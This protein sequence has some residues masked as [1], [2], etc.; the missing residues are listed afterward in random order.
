MRSGSPMK[1]VSMGL[2]R[3]RNRDSLFSLAG[4]SS[5]CITWS[6]SSSMLNCRLLTVIFPLSILLISS[7]SLI[8]E[9]RYSLDIFAFFRQSVTRP[10]SSGEPR[11]SSCIPMMA[12]NGVRISWDILSRKSFFALAFACSRLTAWFRLIISTRAESTRAARNSTTRVIRKITLR[13]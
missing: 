8:T 5:I 3:S 6:S 13:I 10:G 2:S 9:T 1:S 12:F 11:A 4:F 7:T